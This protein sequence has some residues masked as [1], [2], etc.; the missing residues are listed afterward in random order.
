MS[1]GEIGGIS[2]LGGGRWWICPE[3]L[4]HISQALSKDAE[5]SFQMTT[6]GLETSVTV[7]NKNPR[8]FPDSRIKSAPSASRDVLYKLGRFMEWGKNAFLVPF[9]VGREES[10]R[11]SASPVVMYHLVKMPY[12]EESKKFT[13]LIFI[14]RSS[15]RVW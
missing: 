9:L 4:A 12:A 1:L 13:I 10:H 3:C 7:W 8:G 15:F 6:R 11:V 5:P 2:D 14:P